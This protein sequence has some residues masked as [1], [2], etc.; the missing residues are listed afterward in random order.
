MGLHLVTAPIAADG[1]G[2]HMVSGAR[3]GRPKAGECLGGVR[4]VINGFNV[5]QGARQDE[6]DA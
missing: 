3:V 1:M 5:A 2:L 4:G 6:K